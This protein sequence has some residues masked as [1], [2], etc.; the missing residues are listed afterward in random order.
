[1]HCLWA[2]NQAAQAMGQRNLPTLWEFERYAAWERV[3]LAL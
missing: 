1:M 2:G 3:A